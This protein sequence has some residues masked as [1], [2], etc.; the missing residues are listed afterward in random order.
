MTPVLLLP[1]TRIMDGE[2]IGVRPLIGALIAVAGVIGL[3]V[4]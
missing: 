3:T 4:W 2:K 1:I